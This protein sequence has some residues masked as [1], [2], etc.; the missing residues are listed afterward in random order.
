MHTMPTIS[1]NFLGMVSIY[2]HHHAYSSPAKSC[3]SVGMLQYVSA[4]HA[5]SSPAKAAFL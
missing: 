3:I 2:Q 4:H 1:K 5:Y